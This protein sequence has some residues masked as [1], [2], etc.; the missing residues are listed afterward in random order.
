MSLCASVPPV[1][2]QKINPVDINV[3]DHAKFDCETEDAPNVTFKWYKS[4]IE[5]RPSDKYRII[6]HH[7]HSSVEILNP[8]KADSGDYTCKASNQHGYDSCSAPLIVTGKIP[9]GTVYIIT[10]CVCWRERERIIYKLCFVLTSYGAVWKA[11]IDFKN[12]FFPD[13]THTPHQVGQ[14]TLF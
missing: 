13:C 14:L 1:F 4:G 5:I 12:Y 8:V 9:V 10:V 2:K 6:S 3:G 11:G 7:N